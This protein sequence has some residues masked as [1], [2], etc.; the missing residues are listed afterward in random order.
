MPRLSLWKEG[1]HTNDYKFFDRRISEMF[2][3]G[4]T[5][6]NLHKYLGTLD[7]NT[8]TTASSAATTGDSEIEVTSISNLGVGLYVTGTGVQPG[9]KIGAISST[10]LTLTKPLTANVAVGSTVMFDSVLDA[11]QPN[12]TNQSEKN[13]QDLFFLE[14]RDRKY[15]TS[16]YPMRGIYQVTD[17]DFNLSQFGLFLNANTLFIT[18]H[19]NDMLDK[20][21]RRIMAG[22]V[23]ELPHLKDYDPLGAEDMP[24]AL[25]RYYVVQ[26]A[27]RASEGFSV[28]WWPHLWRCKCTPLVDSQ[29]YQD[30]LQ[31]LK[32]TDDPDS[33]SLKDLLSTY[34]K[35]IQITDALVA[36]AE[37]EL[38]KSGYD[39]T[40][41][42][43]VPLNE[44]GS[45]GNPLGQ[46]MN[47]SVNAGSGEVV[48]LD[49]TTP[50][51]SQPA[52]LGGD[53]LPPNG[54]PATAGIVF[55]DS[56]VE[57]DY[58]LR[59]DYVPNRLFRFNG[60]RWNKVEDSV[61]T[62][63]GMGAN[64]TLQG[65]FVN[66]A[67]TFTDFNGQERKKSQPLSKALRPEADN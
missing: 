54:W 20:M 41:L 42:Y 5:G 31:T 59:L 36:Q 64:T 29:E 43:V 11:T 50:D 67:G 4:G 34:N 6:V 35:N 61:R 39:T 3:I 26:E 19:I 12:Y 1:K 23:L 24:A 55:P 30:I 14:N 63:T 10:T 40:S 51:K 60:S 8:R 9:T 16:V 37:S 44:D 17:Q 32:A 66:N 48:N 22:D 15:D 46:S 2:T 56:P 7:Q 65:S 49:A 27:T 62:E 38:P 25:K 13:I 18:F 47:Q 45:L 52:Y 58:C 57:G 53:G 28:T 33:Q 21:G